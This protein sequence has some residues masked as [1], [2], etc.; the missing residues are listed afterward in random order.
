[1]YAF[2]LIRYLLA[3]W[4]LIYG[5][6]YSPDRDHIVNTGVVHFAMGIHSLVLQQSPSFKAPTIVIFFSLRIIRNISVCLA[7][8]ASR[9]VFNVAVLT[10]FSLCHP[11]FR[12][13]T[14]RMHGGIIGPCFGCDTVWARSDVDGTRVVPSNTVCLLLTASVACVS[15]S[16]KRIT[17]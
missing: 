16:Y 5:R 7:R 11:A 17:D 4:I 8:Y 6:I 9:C 2:F 15:E 3:Y 14:Q 10:A 12:L 1:M 13:Y